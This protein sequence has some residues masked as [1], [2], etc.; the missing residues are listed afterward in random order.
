MAS[1]L[2]LYVSEDGADP[3]RVD[4]L[5]AHLRRELDQLD[6]E[7]V[8]PLTLGE[9][10]AGARAFE[11]VAVGGLLVALGNSAQALGK[12]VAVIRDWLS[13]SSGPVRTVRLELG[14]DVLELSQASAAEQDRL[15]ELFVGRHA[16]AG[17]T[18]GGTPQ[19][20]DHRGR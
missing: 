12:V 13:R 9:A 7:R 15:I 10:P 3:E 8:S 16:L 2:S 14:G 5:A 4:T 1:E 20:P 18:H 11:V 6:V 17:G 19:S